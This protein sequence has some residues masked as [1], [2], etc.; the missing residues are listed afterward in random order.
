[1][2]S[3]RAPWAPPTA[4]A[5]YGDDARD[6]LYGL[7]FADDGAPFVATGTAFGPDAGRE[8]LHELAF[9]P[10]EE[11]RIRALAFR[12]L[13]SLGGQPTPDE[14]LPLLG[15]IVEVGLPEGLDVLAAYADGRVRY[16]TQ[17]GGMAIVDG[18]PIVAEEITALLDAAR[19]VAA[20]IGPWLE[21][22]RPPPGPGTLRLSF[23]VG[24][25][26]RFGEGPMTAMS[27]DPLAGPVFAAATRL[28]VVVTGLEADRR[29]G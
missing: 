14:P 10:A 16:T 28:L 18:A 5:P 27:R 6:A 29:G 13:R 20:A 11:S 1:V 25:E 2:T 7:L 8:A 12:S 21:A 4:Y 9:D 26:L 15:L 3:L 24:D 22:R 17:A 19:P 23:L